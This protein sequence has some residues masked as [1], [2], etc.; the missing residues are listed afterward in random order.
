MG[1]R[2]REREKENEQHN[3]EYAGLLIKNLSNISYT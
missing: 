3:G 2:D 1:E